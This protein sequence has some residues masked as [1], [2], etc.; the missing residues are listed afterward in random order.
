MKIKSIT[1]WY[2]PALALGLAAC[3]SESPVEHRERYEPAMAARTPIGSTAKVTWI[4]TLAD[5]RAMKTTG[6]YK[7]NNNIDASATANAPFVPIGFTQE[8]FQGTFDCSTFTIDKLTIK[9]TGNYTGLFAWAVNS[10]FKNV[11]LT[12]VNVEGSAYVGGLAG[13]VRNVD[14]TNSYVTGTVNGLYDIDAQLGMVF[15]GTGDFVRV[16][17]CY[18]TGTVKGKGKYVGGFIGKAYA[19]GTQSAVDE[20][21]LDIDEVFT[22]VTVNPTMPASGAVYAGGLIGHLDGGLIFNINTVGN[23]TGR[24]AAGGVLGYVVNNNPNG[25]QSV[26]R[27]VISRGIVTDA[28]TPNRAGTIGMSTGVFAWCSSYWD[29][30][31]DGGIVNPNMPEPNC[32]T[33]KPSNELKASHPN[34]DKLLVPYI[35]GLYV[36]QSL[37]DAG[38]EPC[39]L[40]SGSDGDWGFGTC[41]STRIWALNSSTEYNTLVRIP[42]PGVQ[43]K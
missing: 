11:R 26:V 7:L 34:P 29:N 15:G 42:N 10:D 13:Y 31:T 21:R 17:R 16:S 39:K 5:L 6:N 2:A 41:G 30:N 28:A 32:Q 33:G 40:K 3:V 35:F 38:A 22:N 18:A 43:P 4:R 36:D 14:L 20:F 9:G 37:V 27:G 8:P 23:V 24:T 25:L 1:K 19:T 12:N